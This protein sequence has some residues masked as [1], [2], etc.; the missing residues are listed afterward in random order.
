M[1][2]LSIEKKILLG[3]R[4]ILWVSHVLIK[5]HREHAHGIF[6]L[7][8]LL[9]STLKVHGALQTSINQKGSAAQRAY[10]L[11]LDKDSRGRRKGGSSQDNREAY[12][13]MLLELC[14]NRK[15]ELKN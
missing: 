15:G 1:H 12:V 4:G 14:L 2:I 7:L 5:G 11:Q 6:C 3:F 10:R 13:Q 9:Y 8:Y